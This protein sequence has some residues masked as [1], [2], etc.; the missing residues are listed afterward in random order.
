[1]TMVNYKVTWQKTQGRRNHSRIDILPT[2]EAK[3]H[4]YVRYDR[5]GDSFSKYLEDPRIYLIVT[6]C[7]LPRAVVDKHFSTA[8]GDWNVYR[9]A[10]GGH[11]EMGGSKTVVPSSIVIHMGNPLQTLVLSFIK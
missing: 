3:H 4:H 6:S 9:D 11:L 7:Q 8:L 2:A 5:D 1:M 10:I